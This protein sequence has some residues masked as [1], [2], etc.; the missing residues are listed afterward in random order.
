MWAKDLGI[1]PKLADRW[2]SVEWL[3]KSDLTDEHLVRT[4]E[5]VV[6]ARRVRRLAEH[7]WSE[8]NLRAIVET[9][10]KPKA[11]ADIPP[12]AEPLALPHAPPE[13]HEDE[14][15]KPTTEPKE[16]E[17][18]EVEPL[19]TKETPRVSSSN[20]GEKRTETQENVPVKKRVM[21]K[22]P[23]RLAT[24]V[25]PPDDPVKR[26]LLQKTD[27]KLHTVNVLPNE[28]RSEALE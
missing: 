15:E 18:M 5:G 3:G 11:T 10:Q 22:S 12:A 23:K 14:K 1:P 25:S 6:Y 8:E 4:D 7:S 28:E 19:D 16:H 24:P 20:R 13:V 21:M 26:R 2:K 17:G 27:L 9:Q